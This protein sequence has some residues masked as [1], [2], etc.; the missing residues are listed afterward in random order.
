MNFKYFFLLNIIF[1]WRVLFFNHLI[2]VDECREL[3][4]VC[5]QGRC[6]N[7][8]G[9]FD[10][11]CPKG[12][13]HDISSGKCIGKMKS[14]FNWSFSFSFI[15]HFHHFSYPFYSLISV[16]MFSIL[17][18]IC[19]LRCWKRE[20]VY[21]SRSSLVSDDFLCSRDFYAWF[22]GDIGRKIRYWSL[23]LV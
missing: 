20:F 15:F 16:Y 13:K 1:V 5:S 3:P 11:F 17:F 22:R 21:Q 6:L 12:F 8:L 9:S 10:C 4:G 2:D 14:N 7:T 18:I 23:S 19:F